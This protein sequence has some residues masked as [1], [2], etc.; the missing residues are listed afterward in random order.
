MTSRFMRSS[1]PAGRPSAASSAR[2]RSSGAAGHGWPT[3]TGDR[4]RGVRPWDIRAASCP[5]G[6][7]LVVVRVAWSRWAANPAAL[8]LT[9]LGW[10]R[11]PSCVSPKPHQRQPHTARTHPHR[12]RYRAE[13][14]HCWRGVRRGRWWWGGGKGY[15]WGAATA[16]CHTG[17]VECGRQVHGRFR[18]FLV[19][20]PS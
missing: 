12:A 13:K 11:P 2:S 17:G 7:D 14:P 4:W 6:C 20:C 9:L 8:P 1:S 16:G 18:S 10:R 5:A 15:C 3:A 19:L